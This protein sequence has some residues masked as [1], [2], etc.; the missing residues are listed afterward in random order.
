MRL[1]LVSTPRS[2]NTWFRRLL[3]RALDSKEFAVHRPCDLNW[4]ELPP[5]CIVQMHWRV[6][7]DVWKISRDFGFQP[8]VIVRHPLDVLISILHFC[9]FELETNHWLGGEGGDEVSIRGKDPTDHAFAAYA[10]GPRAAALLSVSAT[11]MDQPIPHVRFEELVATTE[12]ELR[13]FLWRVG[14][15]PVRP[16][17]DVIDANTLKKSRSTSENHHFWQGRPGLWSRLIDKDLAYRIHAVHSDAFAS[18]GYGVQE[19]CYVPPEVSRSLW[20]TLRAERKIAADERSDRCAQ[21]SSS[22]EC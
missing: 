20:S 9:N 8:I 18:L 14:A 1:L 13:K 2:G 10:T 4:S 11:W 5:S 7:P 6:K 17:P 12:T 21:D 15:E 22:P 3:G 19:A 16:L